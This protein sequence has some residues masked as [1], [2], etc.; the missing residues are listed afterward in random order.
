ML[1]T[2]QNWIHGGAAECCALEKKLKQ[3]SKQVEIHIYLKIICMK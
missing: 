2:Y 1:L 3:I